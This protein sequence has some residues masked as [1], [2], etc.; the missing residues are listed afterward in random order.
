MKNLNDVLENYDR[1]ISIISNK[2]LE[3][4]IIKQAQINNVF[5]LL[6]DDESK[7]LY[8]QELLMCIFRNFLTMDNPSI[9]AGLMSRKEFSC[10][11]EKA[12]HLYPELVFPDNSEANYIANYCKAATFILEQ[13]RYHNIVK[14][15][16]DD[17]CLDVGGCLGDTALYM[18]NNGAASV[19]SFEIDK[20]N[21]DYMQKTFSNLKTKP[22]HIINKAV[23]DKSDSF[24]YT[25]DKK[26]LGGG[27]ISK[28]KIN[29]DSYG[30]E[31]ITIDN[32]CHEINLQPNFIKMD[33]E[34]AELDAIKGST[35]I[36]IN[37]KPKLAISI[38]H[39]W[40]HR[41]EIPLLLKE[42]LPN[43]NFYLKKSHPTAET[44]LFGKEK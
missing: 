12:E 41:W 20:N 25:P 13:Y 16:N 8:G 3:P 11:I 27:K 33:I 38:Y 35:D 1:I 32:F 42:I 30:V 43:Y 5:N 36:L 6:S 18:I 29:Q 15:E 23:S 44:I 22:I 40:S 4:L 14:I 24:Y 26:N 34:G 10:N 21:I 17:I 2:H 9:F 19:Y 39:K 31:S 28:D 7:Y 37:C